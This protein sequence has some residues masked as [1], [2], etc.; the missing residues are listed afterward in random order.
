[1]TAVV[2]G[3]AEQVAE[4]L[5]NFGGNKPEIKPGGEGNASSTVEPITRLPGGKNYLR[6]KKSKL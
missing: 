3:I 6:R 2:V 4:D 5:I 1:M